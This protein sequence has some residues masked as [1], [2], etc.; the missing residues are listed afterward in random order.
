MNNFRIPKRP[1][2]RILVLGAALGL[3]ACKL[4]PGSVAVPRL[5]LAGQPEQAPDSAPDLGFGAQPGTSDHDTA[6]F[7]AGL[8]GSGGGAALASARR[9]DAWQSHARQMDRAFS[10][11]EGRL[12]AIRS[13][14][15]DAL[16]NTGGTLF[17]PFSGP[18]LL[19]ADAFFPRARGVILCG[20]EPVGAVPDLS[21]VSD[22]ALPGA[23]ASL[24][25]SI[26]TPLAASYFITEDMRGDL[27]AGEFKGVTPVLY[28]FLART[29]HRVLAAD[30]VALSPSGQVVPRPG[31][32]T[33][34]APGVRIHAASGATGH[35]T[36]YYFRTDLSDSSL[37][38]DRRFLAFVQ[39]QN[40][41]ATFVK[42]AS[43]LMHSGGFTEVRKAV[44][45]AAPLLVQDPTGVPYQ[46]LAA[47]GWD[48][49]L[50]GNYHTTLDLFR[51]YY[52]PDLAAAYR[53]GRARP[54]EFGV[55]YEWSAADSS[56][57]VAKRRPGEAVAAR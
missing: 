26:A 43:Y 33:G 9:T 42:S 51:S 16:P 14:R 44:Q 11:A 35:R 2:L 27:G 48:V 31:P 6:R 38:G 55:G 13:W 49:A 53:K 10:A 20:L 28:T 46:T 32:A 12:S 57:I 41:S 17:Y 34:T 19:F 54:M 25:R 24:R 18:D 56:L 52:Q 1:F 22:G 4:P 50:H 15:R 39:S 29:G 21:R 23:L 5:A 36:I 30:P 7:L 47:G 8:P 37:R 3:N 40:P 45:T